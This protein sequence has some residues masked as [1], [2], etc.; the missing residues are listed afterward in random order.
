MDIYERKPN[1]NH[2]AQPAA[3][4]NASALP[5]S[6][7]KVSGSACLTQNVRQINPSMR[8]ITR[9]FNQIEAGVWLIIA[10]GFFFYCVKAKEEKRK[11]GIICCIAFFIF[12][13]S[14]IIESLT[15]A[16]WRP[17]WLLAIKTSCVFTFIYC[18]LKYRR[19]QKTK[20]PNQAPQTTICTG[21]DRV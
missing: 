19:I 8:D 3:T 2:G 13:I 7:F 10:I 9:L 18:Y 1:E 17:L 14:D 16:W 12:G 5:L 6:A 20:T 21:A 4:D 11:I 15:G